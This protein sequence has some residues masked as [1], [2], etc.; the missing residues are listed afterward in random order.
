MQPRTFSQCRDL[1]EILSPPWRTK[2][3]LSSADRQCNRRTADPSLHSGLLS[4]CLRQWPF[5][6]ALLALFIASTE[7]SLAADTQKALARFQTAEQLLSELQSKPV[8]TRTRKDYLRAI[9]AYREVY[10]LAPT[11]MRADPSAYEVAEL[12]EQMGRHFNDTDVL[13]GAVKQ[14]RFLLHEYPGTKHRFE[15]LLAIGDIEGSELHD[16]DAARAAY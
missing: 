13:A 1:S 10:H 15:S 12:T 3:Q 14:Y 9:D 6:V 4:S 7:R 8:A 16:T 2:D 11:S 5:A